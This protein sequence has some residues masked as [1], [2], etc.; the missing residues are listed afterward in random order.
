MSLYALLLN[1][2]PS[3]SICLVKSSSSRVLV[4]WVN[5]VA[6]ILAIPKPSGRM[7]PSRAL[8]ALKRKS[9]STIGNVVARTKA[10]GTP[11]ALVKRSI[12]GTVTDSG[13]TFCKLLSLFMAWMGMS[14][15]PVMVEGTS[16]AAAGK[17]AL[18]RPSATPIM[19]AR[20]A[21]EQ[22]AIDKRK[23]G[24]IMVWVD[25]YCRYSCIKRQS[26]VLFII[27]GHCCGCVVRCIWHCVVCFDVCRG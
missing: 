23:V 3:I 11:E 22:V 5:M 4:P 19:A 8:P 2:I 21:R 16:R 12:L 24:Y 27:G 7:L 10:T 26:R 17:A 9:I 14:V 1:E 25:L 6:V 20:L 13:R 18:I 15:R